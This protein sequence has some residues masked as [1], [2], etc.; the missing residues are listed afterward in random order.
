MARHYGPQD[1]DPLDA[2]ATPLGDDPLLRAR[3]GVKSLED[4]LAAMRADRLR[5]EQEA[6]LRAQ[7]ESDAMLA[8]AEDQYK[9]ERESFDPVG[10]PRLGAP[11]PGQNG[12]FQFRARGDGTEEVVEANPAASVDADFARW[13]DEEPGSDRQRMYN[14]T[15][16]AEAMAAR[17]E[18]RLERAAAE[19]A[20]YG[21]AS[22][23]NWRDNITDEQWQARADRAEVD[24]RQAENN[25]ATRDKVRGT[26]SYQNYEAKQAKLEANRV[27]MQQ[28]PFLTLG[29]PGLNEWQQFVLA[30]GMLGG[31]AR[32]VDPNARDA[33]SAQNAM[34]LIQADALAGMFDPAGRESRAAAQELREI[35]LPAPQR[36]ALSRRRGE[37]IGSGLSAEHVTARWDHWMNNFGASGPAARARGFR[38]EMRGLGYSDTD[39]DAYFSSHGMDPTGSPLVTPAPPAASGGDKPPLP[40]FRGGDM[41]KPGVGPFDRPGA[42]PRPFG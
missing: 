41:P 42:A 39:I 29:D 25:K 21:V 32:V 18:Q 2:A 26:Q 15:G 40:P 24:R 20:K 6:R 9:A 19:Q 38:S 17:E 10:R 12:R 36:A 7:Q 37:P 33:E 28:N 16:Y 4:T 23:E 14:P 35:T 30:Q 5:R 11:L 13:A 3:A 22:G 8:A 31:R 1:L 27:Q 34:R